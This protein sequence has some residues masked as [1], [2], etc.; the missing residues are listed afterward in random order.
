MSVNHE[1]AFYA[2]RYPEGVPLKKITTEAIAEVLFDIYS[3]VGIPEDVLTDQEPQ[4]VRVYAG[5]IP[6]TQYQGPD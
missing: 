4:S 6:I 1:S 2:T 5:G 3:R